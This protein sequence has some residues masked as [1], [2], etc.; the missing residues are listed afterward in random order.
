VLVWQNAKFNVKIKNGNEV[1][2]E[3]VVDIKW[4]EVRSY[5]RVWH[6]DFG[7]STGVVVNTMPREKEFVSLIVPA[8]YGRIRGEFYAY[9]YEKIN[10]SYV[11]GDLSK[12]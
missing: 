2:Y 10:R 11:T 9:D 8:T 4:Q 3:T 5:G 1:V 6:Q 7:V 12:E